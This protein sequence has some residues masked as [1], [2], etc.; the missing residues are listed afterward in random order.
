MFF[1][2]LYYKQIHVASSRWPGGVRR[3]EHDGL[4]SA[5]GLFK[6]EWNHF[7]LRVCSQCRTPES[8]HLN[9]INPVRC[10]FRQLKWFY[11]AWHMPQSLQ[12]LQGVR[13]ELWQPLLSDLVC[14]SNFLRIFL[15]HD[16]E[17]VFAAK[18]HIRPAMKQA[19]KWLHLPS[20]IYSNYWCVAEPWSRKVVWVWTLMACRIPGLTRFSAVL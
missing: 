17:E 16:I 14:S 13:R 19:Q 1:P 20:A 2:H 9:L 8:H 4:V 6:A 3:A 12:T 18:I 15:V 11:N 5:S 10:H 7:V